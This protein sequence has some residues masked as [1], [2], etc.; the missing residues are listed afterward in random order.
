MPCAGDDD[1]FGIGDLRSDRG[2][3]NDLGLPATQH[4]TVLQLGF[5]FKPW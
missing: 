3:R 2:V 4:Q 1:E 5:R